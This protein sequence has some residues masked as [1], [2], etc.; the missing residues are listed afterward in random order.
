MQSD[1]KDFYFYFTSFLF[2]PRSNEKGKGVGLLY[3][4]GPV[5]RSEPK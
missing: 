5:H 3:A 1:Y 2:R 4:S